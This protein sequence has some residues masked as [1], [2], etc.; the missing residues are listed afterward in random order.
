MAS[1]YQ[2]R[3]DDPWL[4]LGFENIDDIEA[5]EWRAVNGKFAP[6]QSL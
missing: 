3:R 1:E 4:G 5:C 2:T 6:S